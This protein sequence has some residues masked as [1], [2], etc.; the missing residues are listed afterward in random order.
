MSE[1]SLPRASP[2][3]DP[4]LSTSSLSHV[5]SQRKETERAL[6]G[7]RQGRKRKRGRNAPSR[8]TSESRGSGDDG[9]GDEAEG[10]ATPAKTQAEINAAIIAA[11]TNKTKA[12][13]DIR[14][15]VNERSAEKVLEELMEGWVSSVYDHFVLP[16]VIIVEN[17]VVKH[18][19]FCKFKSTVYCT[20]VYYDESTSNLNRHDR[21]CPHAPANAT[22]E[23]RALVA[24][25][26]G[27]QYT[28]SRHRLKIVVWIARR[29]RPYSIVED[30]ELL[31]IFRDLH[32]PC[33]TVSRHTVSRDIIEVHGLTKEAVISWLQKVEG[34]IHV[35]GDGWTAPSV[36]SFIGVVVQFVEKASIVSLVL[37]FVKLTKAHTGQYLA[38]RLAE[39]LQEFKIDD[40]VMG[41]TGDNASNNDTMVAELEVLLPNFRGDTS[42]VRCA[43]HILNLVAKAILSAFAKKIDTLT[44][45]FDE[46]IDDATLHPTVRHAAL[47]GVRMLNKYY[48]KTDESNVYR[49]AMM[50]HPHYKLDYFTKAGWETEWIAEARR[51][52]TTEWLEHYKRNVSPSTTAT[53]ASSSS[54]SASSSDRFANIRN[55]FNFH[56]TATATTVDPL[57]EWFA[58]P[59]ISSSIKIDPI[60]YWSD[61]KLGGHPL[62]QMA[63]DYLSVPATSTDVERAF[64]RGGL[65]VSKLRHSLSD[66]STRCQTVLGLWCG[67]PGLLP[68][69]TIIKTFDDKAKRSG[70]KKSKVGEADDAASGPIVIE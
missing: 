23:S 33:K 10:S 66:Q 14:M 68:T 51:L 41:F 34:K 58:T 2:A 13:F 4:P 22:P 52:I 16:P 61:M 67:V 42:R 28:E 45:F 17:G 35:S 15:R 43:C 20:R 39:C 7:R 65:T 38:S 37:D 49:I 48:S 21:D 1:P 19:F 40:R 70:N 32:G 60:K 18:R 5:S 62:A 12:A 56:R 30:D 63:L 8:Q 57:E 24:Y 54:T 36:I 27:S 69:D 53:A 46:T 44:T 47:R 25:V 29:V 26:G 55:R 6:E 59:A 31:D 11:A 3:A 50:L 64:S 9:S